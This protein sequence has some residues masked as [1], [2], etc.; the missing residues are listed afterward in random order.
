MSLSV[1]GKAAVVGVG[2]TTY[3]KRGDS[4]DPEF[5][6]VLK[7]ILAACAD[8]G[9][10]PKE[11]DGYSSYS[12]DRNLPSR[13]HTALGAKELR[14]SNMQWG[15]GGGGAAASVGNAAAA[16]AAGY[17][18]CVVA[19]RGLAQGQFGRFGAGRGGGTISG[20]HALGVPYGLMS[21]AQMYAMRVTRLFH[22][23]NISP[24]TLR[25]VALA[26]YHHAQQNPRAIMYQHPL[27]ADTYDDSRWIVE[28][29]RL[30]D[31]CLENDG[32]AAVVLVSAQR[33]RELSNR[34]AYLLSAQQSGPFRSGASSHNVPDY[35][36]SSFKTGAPRLFAQ[37]GVTPEDVNVVQSYENFTGGVVMSLIEHGFCDYVNANEVITFDNLVSP[38]GRLPLNTSGG[39]LAECYMHGLGLVVEAVRQVRGDSSNQVPNVNVSF[40]NAGPMV[41][42]ASAAIFGTE[43]VL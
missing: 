36:T 23:H 3:Y 26:S 4:P 41:E 28:P 21:P 6:L 34:P 13:L 15:S 7:A 14:F 42:V 38:F 11:I 39:N 5:V 22:E 37:A 31:C 30:Y 43:A 32:A 2:E 10:S 8:A 16:I 18:D 24:D 9:I 40:V 35:A 1:R 33:A 17:A 12:N 27:D 19:F 29:F 25:A 20:E